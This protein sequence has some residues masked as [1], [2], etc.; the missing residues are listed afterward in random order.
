MTGAPSSGRSSRRRCPVSTY[1][2]GASA[3]SPLALA[4]PLRLLALAQIILGGARGR[5]R[6]GG[7]RVEA[8][9]GDGSNPA[10]LAH[11]DGIEARRAAGEHPVTAGELCGNPLDGALHAE[12]LAAADAVERLLLLQ[13]VRARGCGP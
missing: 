11:F 6:R 5:P 4:R 3:R 9:L 7:M 8:I 12:R 13:H 10:V 1:G 2:C